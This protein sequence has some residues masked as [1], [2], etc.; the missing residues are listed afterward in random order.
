MIARVLALGRS[1]KK[2]VSY[3]KTGKDGRQ[4]QRDRVEWVEFRNLPT[5]N[6]DTAAC[7]MAATAS[8]SVSGTQTAVYHFSISCDPGDPVD[9]G[10][11]RRVADR[12]IRD[13]GLE[14]HQVL[15]FAHK[16]RSHPH[17]HF[18]VN[19]VHPER[20]TLWRTWRDY[21]RIERSLRAQEQ[22]LGLQIV[23]GWNS[24]V[25]RDVDGGLRVPGEHETGLQRVY[26]APNARR[27]DAEFLCDVRARAAPLL[28]QARGW[29]ELERGLAEQG[30]SLRVKGGGFTLTDGTREVKAS[31]VGR[32]CS[33]YHLEKRLGPYPDYRARLAVAQLPPAP[34]TPTVQPEVAPLRESATVE[35]Q[36]PARQEPPAPPLPPT[37]QIPPRVEGSVRERRKPQFGDAGHG[38]IELFGGPP[39]PEVERPAPAAE[40]ARAPQPKRKERTFLCEVRDRAGPVLERAGTWAELERGLSDHGLSL[41]EKGGGFVVTDGERDVKASEVGRAFSRFHLEKRLGQFPSSRARGSEDEV[42]TAPPAP[43]AE[44]DPAARQAEQLALPLS[45]PAVQEGAATPARPT[46]RFTLYD[47]GTVCGVRDRDGQVFF[48]E[49]RE[50]AVAEVERANAI[51]ALYPG[52]HLHAPSPRDGRRLA[53]RARTAAPA[54]AGGT[55]DH[56]PGA[57]RL[58]G[59]VAPTP[60]RCTRATRRAE[61][62][63][64]SPGTHSR[65]TDASAG[66]YIDLRAS[67]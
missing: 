60:A 59:R 56:G 11:L 32:G 65:A 55:P 45:A 29:A 25:V 12:T 66:G 49:T 52:R 41:R 48:A 44:P 63:R 26:P 62:S 58:R 5:R 30:L 27:G 9:G 34:R 46:Q 47:D 22:E 28:E 42:Q 3:L 53:G 4:L 14:E 21:Y 24:V 2:L 20:G 57:Q 18:V 15:I 64:G 7:M 61:S 13:L 35:A 38:I 37:P 8:E 17:L 33:R 6:P 1:F 16:D 39:T 19:R 43:A 54:R 67:G 31:E 23:P 36:T 51:A 10:T 40:R 50:R